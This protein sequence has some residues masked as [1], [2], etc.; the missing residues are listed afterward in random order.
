MRAVRT[1]AA[2]RD[3]FALEMHLGLKAG[4]KVRQQLAALAAVER[5]GK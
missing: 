1:K 4:L 2:R 3:S 5:I